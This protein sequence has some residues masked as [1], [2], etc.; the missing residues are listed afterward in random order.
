[1]GWLS[2]IIDVGT[3]ILGGIFGGGGSNIPDLLGASAPWLTGLMP[4]QPVMTPEQLALIEQ[5]RQSQ[6]VAMEG[7]IA[8]QALAA[9]LLGQGFADPNYYKADA[10]MMGAMAANQLEGERRR[11]VARGGRSPFTTND[12]DRDKFMRM[13]QA[14]Q[15]LTVPERALAGAGAIGNLNASS[16]VSTYAG[17]AGG[18]LAA[19]LAGQQQLGLAL[20]SLGGLIPGVLQGLSGGGGGGSQG[21][22]YQPNYGPYITNTSGG[23]GTT[24][25]PYY[26]GLF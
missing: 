24:S 25:D 18:Q 3:D 26:G 4:Q 13:Y 2:E 15:G 22:A 23:S 10:T 19:N 20:D 9:R 21:I 14:L 17:P 11:Q 5:T 7:Q 1:M 16:P 6:Q 8:N 12:F